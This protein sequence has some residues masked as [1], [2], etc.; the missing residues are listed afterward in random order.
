MIGR[1][2][3]RRW[4]V[5][6][7][8][9]TAIVALVALAAFASAPRAAQTQEPPPITPPPAPTPTPVPLGNPT[10]L[11]A[12]TGP[13][14]GQVSLY[15]T[16]ADNAT[17]HWVWSV[18]LDNTGGKWTHGETDSAVIDGLEAGEEYWFRVIAGREADGETARWS[19]WSNWARAAAERSI[20]IPI[21]CI[22]TIRTPCQFLDAVQEI[23]GFDGFRAR[24]K[25]RTNGRVIFKMQSYPQLGLDYSDAINLIKNRRLDAG[26]VY[27]AHVSGNLA[28][29]EAVN[30]WGL[31]PNS[32]T[33]F[34]VVDATRDD[35]HRII[36]QATDGV[37]ITE[38]YT[39][40]NYFFSAKELLSP[41]DFTD[42]KIR[43]YR[44]PLEEMLTGIGAAPHFVEYTDVYG[45]LERQSVDAAVSCG[46]CGA[47]Q[48]WYE[49]ADYLHGP[50]NGSANVSWLVINR[51]LWD[52]IPPDLKL[53]IIEE[54]YRHREKLRKL[55]MTVWP[56]E[57]IAVN[58][59]S[60]MVHA[61]LS[62]EMHEA[63]FQAHLNSALPRWVERAGGP[64]AEAVHLF[65]E[66]I[67]PIVNVSINPDGSVSSPAQPPVGVPGRVAINFRETD[68]R[69]EAVAETPCDG[70]TA[71]AV[72]DLHGGG[73]P[74]GLSCING[75]SANFNLTPLVSDGHYFKIQMVCIDRALA[76]CGLT[77][78]EYRHTWDIGFVERVKRR[79]NGQVQFLV[80][81]FP[82][83]GIADGLDTLRLLEEGLLQAASI[84]P[85]HLDDSHATLDIG[86]LTGLYPTR[87]A[88]LAVIDAI[89]PQM[90][91][92]TES[93]GGVQ[94][95]YLMNGDYYLFAEGEV[96]DDPGA[97]QGIRVRN[98]VNALHDLL[99][100]LGAVTVFT[101]LADVYPIWGTHGILDGA[102][103]TAAV[104][105]GQR[106]HE[107]AD[108]IVGPLPAVSH[109]WL[110][111]NRELWGEMP[112]DLR[113]IILEEGARHAYLNRHLVTERTEP[114]AVRKL[115]AAGLKHAQFSYS[116]Q[117]E[118][119]RIAIEKVVPN[120][121][122]RAGGDSDAVRLF[123]AVVAPIVKVRINP[124]GSASAIE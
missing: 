61:E 118:M 51:D 105:Y 35:V 113:N 112:P 21:A 23:H 37:V 66:A 62:L 94:I 31:Y 43:S 4:A 25:E 85:G 117:D 77:M 80:T 67:A 48:R 58:T 30:L 13:N 42:L 60:G 45:A 96:H 71:A 57:V 33:Q 100:G 119:R 64:D 97:W 39:D 2:R 78:G 107:V 24:V 91:E 36:E 65:N 70:A 22:T 44:A 104:G 50:I 89:Q 73:S 116:I 88:H 27:P 102:I 29:L 49:V 47:G 93:R 76:G 122:E 12:K 68:G 59:E 55:A 106:W 53:I 16:P 20:F 87:Q 17:V 8:V 108:Y 109:S 79:T 19:R 1:D 63:L 40:G 6:L 84:Y 3:K 52:S 26:E 7:V 81:S 110:A 15:W 83:M 72:P 75:Q 32:V 121:V 46:S 18:K 120:W 41:D 101:S 9:M 5:A 103:A 111:V 95:A 74:T 69:L 38:H 14:A 114:M 82:Q 98:H 56:E 99:S 54:G 92:L 124:D 34:A 11:T 28:M 123:N 115:T 90:A 10:N 86:N